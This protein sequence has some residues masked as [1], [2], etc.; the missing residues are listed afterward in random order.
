MLASIMAQK[1]DV[2]AAVDQAAYE[3]V[4]TA[5]L[6]AK[7]EYDRSAPPST[8][9]AA[10]IYAPRLAYTRRAL[11]INGID[12]ILQ[13]RAYLD[14]RITHAIENRTV[15]SMREVRE[16]AHVAFGDMRRFA[17]RFNKAKWLKRVMKHIKKAHVPTHAYLLAEECTNRFIDIGLDSYVRGGT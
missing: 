10:H 11:Q 16:S 17:Q 6:R 8:P 1:D 12:S 7:A 9:T 4:Q 15:T 5:I 13:L 2:D 3:L 14:K